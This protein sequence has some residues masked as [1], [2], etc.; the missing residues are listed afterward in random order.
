MCQKLGDDKA[1]FLPELRDSWVAPSE[2]SLIE[3][4]LKGNRRSQQRLAQIRNLA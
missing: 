2:L 3:T 1:H 4:E